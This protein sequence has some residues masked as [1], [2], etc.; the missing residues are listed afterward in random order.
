MNGLQVLRFFDQYEAKI[1][2]LAQRRLKQ[3][4]YLLYGYYKAIAV[5]IRHMKRE[6]KNLYPPHLESKIP[7]PDPSRFQIIQQTKRNPFKEQSHD[8]T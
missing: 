8:K 2:A 5:H 3:R 6:F 7:P 1:E 4:K